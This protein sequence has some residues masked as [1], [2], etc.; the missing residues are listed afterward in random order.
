MELQSDFN[1]AINLNPDEEKR[2]DSRTIT[3]KH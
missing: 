2:T 3:T 1:I